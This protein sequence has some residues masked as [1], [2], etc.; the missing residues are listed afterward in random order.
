MTCPPPWSWVRCCATSTTTSATVW[1]ET[2]AAAMVRVARRGPVGPRRGPSRAHGHHYALVDVDGLAPGS[3]RRTSWRSTAQQ[4]W[5][6]APGFA[7]PASVIPTLEP[8]KP[9]RMAFGSCRVSVSH[10][11]EGNEALGVDAL[12]AFALHLAGVTD[13][14]RAAL[15]RPGA[16]PRRPGLRRRDQPAMQE[17]IARRDP[18]Q[19]PGRAEGLRGVRPALPARLERPGQPLAALDAAQ[20]DDLRRPRHPRRLEH[21][22]R[23]APR[24][25][26][27]RLVARPRR[28]R[29]GLLLGLPAPGQPQPGRRAP[30]TRCGQRVVDARRAGASSTSPTRSTSSPTRADRE[31]AYATAGASRATS[32]PR[33]GWS[34]STRGPPGC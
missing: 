28:R 22:P 7:D 31:P 34:W 3:R 18:E 17:V 19:P 10:D 14:D 24:H 29:P 33:R 6:E 26:G 11:E 1:V 30:R 23:L 32:T 16:L 12:R 15:A 25:G 20:R 9:L 27:H 4:V 13:E 8:G 2:D 21:Q 5:P